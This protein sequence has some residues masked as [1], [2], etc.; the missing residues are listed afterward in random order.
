LL[1]FIGCALALGSF[2]RSYAEEARQKQLS[3]V[4][5]FLLLPPAEAQ[6]EKCEGFTLDPGVQRF[7]AHRFYL[8]KR[9]KIAAHHFTLSLEC[10]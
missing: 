3:I 7:D 5:Y 4:D 10:R 9:M 8:M 6:R 2:S 1:V